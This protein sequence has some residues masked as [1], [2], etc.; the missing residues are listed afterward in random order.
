MSSEI[1]LYTMLPFILH[2]YI[3]QKMNIKIN[4]SYI[5]ILILILFFFFW[6]VD[7]QQIKFSYILSSSNEYYKYFNNIKLSYSIIFLFIPIFYNCMKERT[8][9]L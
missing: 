4:Q 3:Y 8:S 6:G 7:L 2:I 9:L 1:G 5:Y